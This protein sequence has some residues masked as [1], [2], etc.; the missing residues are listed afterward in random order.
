MSD[1]ELPLLGLISV[2]EEQQATVKAVLARLA[3]QEEML[4]Q[5]RQLLAGER[6]AL[7]AKMDKLQ[8]VLTNVGPDLETRTRGAVR[9]AISESMKEAGDTAM[10]AMR[11]AAKPVLAQLD[12]VKQTAGEVNAS[13]R[14]AVGWVTWQL[15][16]RIGAVVVACLA[17]LVLANISIHWWTERDIALDK[18]QKAL[19]EAEIAGLEDKRDQLVSLGARATLNRCGDGARPCIRINEAAGSFGDPPDYRIIKGY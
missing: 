11:D 6:Q 18:A 7:V 19:L 17:V 8:S 10:L 12:G 14:R 15:L 3:A 9:L 1:P 13:L 16:W 2:A 5:E 4:K